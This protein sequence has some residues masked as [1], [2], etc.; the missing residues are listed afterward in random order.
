[1]MVN[2][3]GDCKLFQLQ[4]RLQEAMSYDDLESN[5]TDPTVQLNLS[6]I[7]RYLNG[8]PTTVPSQSGWPIFFLYSFFVA[9]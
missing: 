3:F 9:S 5:E 8:P 1:M 4:I 2:E 6:R 7:E